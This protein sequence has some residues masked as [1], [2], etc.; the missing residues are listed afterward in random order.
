MG[1]RKSWVQLRL[2]SFARAG[3]SRTTVCMEWRSRLFRT[4]AYTCAWHG[5][6]FAC[7]CPMYL[8]VTNE[9]AA[10]WHGSRACKVSPVFLTRLRKVWK[11]AVRKKQQRML[12]S[13]PVTS[14]RA[15][16]GSAERS[17]EGYGDE[18]FSVQ[19]GSTPRNLSWRKAFAVSLVHIIVRSEATCLQCWQVNWWGR[20]NR[21]SYVSSSVIASPLDQK[22]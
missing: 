20:Q 16:V 15:A 8:T 10:I 12:N 1:T 6:A 5:Q 18:A 9:I 14:W 7:S 11:V 17:R 21:P 2:I 19:I 13:A 4:P 22:S 3:K